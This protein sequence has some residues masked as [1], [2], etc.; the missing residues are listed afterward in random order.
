MPLKYEI[1]FIP[2]EYIKLLLEGATV[3]TAD[4][5]QRYCKE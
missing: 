2:L 3:Y 1:V 5:I 4:N